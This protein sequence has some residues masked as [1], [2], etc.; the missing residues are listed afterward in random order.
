MD[1]KLLEPTDWQVNEVVEVNLI[2]LPVSVTDS[3]G[4]PIGNLG[5]KNFRVLENG[6]PQ[7]IT[8]FDAASNL[9]IAVGLLIDHSGSMKPRMQATKDAAIAFL[10]SILKPTDRAFVAPF[11][12][13]ST[14]DV[15]FVSDVP[16]LQAQVDSIPEANGGTSLYDAIVTAL[17]RFRNL[18]GRKALIILTDGE[19]TTSRIPYDEMLMYSR[20]SR[21][22]LYFI[23]IG[24]GFTDFSGTAKMKSLAAETGGVVYLIKNVKT[25]GETYAQL[26][27]DLRS[28]YLIAYSSESSR[29][30]NRYRTIEVKV[31]RQDATVRTIRGFLP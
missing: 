6:T 1:G 17:Y 23:G 4:L 14:R 19:D 20:A 29:N 24:L 15:P 28:Q 9:P 16:A 31:D 26:E 3:A 18:Q 21:V 2:E 27:K 12:F 8:N 13:E 11:A 22:P 25:L 10:K 30:D 7:K 5:Q